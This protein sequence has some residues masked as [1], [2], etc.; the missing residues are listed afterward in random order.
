MLNAGE[1]LFDEENSIFRFQ[2]FGR[3]T[4]TKMRERRRQ[5]VCSFVF[6][7]EDGHSVCDKRNYSRQ[8]QLGRGHLVPLCHIFP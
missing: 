4:T 2:Q 8:W 1:S 5:P 6:V 3:S 7:T